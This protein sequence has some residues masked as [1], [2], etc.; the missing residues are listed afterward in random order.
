LGY[1]LLL[2]AELPALVAADRVDRTPI[3]IAQQ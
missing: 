3:Q 2:L 1:S